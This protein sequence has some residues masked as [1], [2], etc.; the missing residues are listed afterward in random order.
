MRW[1]QRAQSTEYVV[2]TVLKS[3]QI[4]RP[5]LVVA[6]NDEGGLESVRETTRAT[7]C[8]LG[9]CC[10]KPVCKWLDSKFHG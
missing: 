5:L 1:L 9:M 10:N 2:V 8:H 7:D 3:L 4:V 6:E